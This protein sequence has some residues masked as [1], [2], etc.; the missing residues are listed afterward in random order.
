DRNG[1]LRTRLSGHAAARA[2]RALRPAGQGGLH[3]FREAVRVSDRRC[4]D[5]AAVE[6]CGQCRL[7][8]PGTGIAPAACTW[9]P[10]RRPTL[11]APATAA[12]PP[13]VSPFRLRM[14][15]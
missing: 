13:L 4:G 15:N 3:G 10:I 1:P 14:T 5:R 8:R 12:S 11:P 9:G 2:H 6:A 7:G